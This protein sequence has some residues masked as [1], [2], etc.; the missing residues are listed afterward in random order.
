MYIGKNVRETMRLSLGRWGWK[1]EGKRKGKRGRERERERKRWGG[2]GWRIA[3]EAK[4]PQENS[5][6]DVEGRG[7]E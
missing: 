4:G 6:L 7:N 3:V 5:V 2:E 1:K